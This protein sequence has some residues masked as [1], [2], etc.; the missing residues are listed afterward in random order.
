MDGVEPLVRRL[1][2]GTSEV[3]RN[4]S[5]AL[6]VC[7]ADEATAQEI[8]I[9]GGLKILQEIHSSL[10]RRNQFTA[11]DLERLLHLH[12]H[13]HKYIYIYFFFFKK[14]QYSVALG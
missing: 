11:A 4:A 5:W 7:A 12:T 8:C 3:V 2:S 10:T 6:F 9:H 14:K 1:E 13:T